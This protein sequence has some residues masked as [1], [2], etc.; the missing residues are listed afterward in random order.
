MQG[1]KAGTTYADMIA[2]ALSK[3]SGG[4][5]AFTE[6]CD[7]I[8]A[9]FTDVLNWKL[10]R[11]VLRACRVCVGVCFICVGLCYLFCLYFLFQRV[12]SICCVSM[13][14]CVHIGMCHVFMSC[15]YTLCF[16][17]YVTVFSECVPASVSVWP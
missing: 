3:V 15:V 13:L 14:V 17:W 11:C 8:E 7:I 10:E 12:M 5:G 1:K 2:H 4:R 6:I 9:E 16:W